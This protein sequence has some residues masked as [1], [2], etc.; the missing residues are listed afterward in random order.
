MRVVV[1]LKHILPFVFSFIRDRRCWLVAGQP[2][3][4]S[5]EFHRRRADA[6]VAAIGTLGP[7]FV[8]LAQVFAGRAD[9]FPEEYVRAL[10][11]LT[12]QVPPVPLEA[13][14][15]TIV[16]SYGKPATALFE[17]FEQTP[18][19]AA[20]LGQVHRATYE[21]REVVV[22]VLRP[23]IE[24]LVASDVQA[25]KR[26]LR[27]IERRFA[28]NPH[29]RG[30]R[31]AVEEFSLRIGD[32]MDFRKEAENAERIR[33]NFAGN[34]RV[35]IPRIEPDLVRQRVLV[36]EYMQGVRIDRADSVAPGT[37]GVRHARSSDIVASVMEL[38][39]QMMLVDGLFHADPHPGN[40]LV[41]P[42]GRIILLDFGMVVPVP[43]ETRWHLI[44]TVFASIRKDVDGVVAGF[45][46]LG[47][48]EPG[49]DPQMVRDLVQALLELAH[50]RTTVPERIEMLLAD[51]V[52]GT[53]YDWPV[54]LPREMVYFARAAALIEGLG[55][56]Y[57]PRFN[58]IVFAAPIALKMR[59]RI[60]SSLG[61]TPAT[62]DPNE[63]IYTLSG[64]VGAVAGVFTRAGKSFLSRLE[65]EFEAARP[66][67]IPRVEMKRLPPAAN[68]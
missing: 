44:Q 45:D 41:S 68:Q 23:G 40:L 52:M 43:R 38:Y 16:E 58:P 25:A 8:K 49:A 29:V 46:A 62:R 17:R 47:V 13:V 55:V 37:N 39:I 7:T 48:L 20:S 67:D 9:L 18:I 54:T 63:W 32:E 12:D 34:R 57:D 28:T 31:V 30:L 56:H 24:R 60:L 36:M 64:V 14:E 2:V 35:M 51:Q 26:I 22:K 33:A 42:D 11:T 10:S 19:A 50:S 21:G 53:L 1:I 61:D 4:R 27:V 15:R 65:A 3:P 5:S 6:L 59:R 66:L